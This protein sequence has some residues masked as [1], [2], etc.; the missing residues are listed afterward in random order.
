MTSS[1][2]WTVFGLPRERI[3]EMNR[4]QNCQ[5]TLNPRHLRGRKVEAGPLGH[6]L[7]NVRWKAF[8]TYRLHL[9][10]G[11]DQVSSRR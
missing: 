2:L 6:R 3:L 1:A 11:G 5:S 7:V 9:R 4:H 8:R 10:I